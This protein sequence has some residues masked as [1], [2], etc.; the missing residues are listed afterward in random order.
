[1]QDPQ[2]VIVEATKG[3]VEELAKRNEVGLRRMYAILESD[4]YPKA[5]RRIRDIGA[6]NPDGARLIKCDLM[7]MFDDILA[8]DTDEVT[9]AEFLKE[10]N[11]AEHARIAKAPKAIRLQEDREAVDVINRDMCEIEKEDK[12]PVRIEMRGA[13][14]QRRN[15]HR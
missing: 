11:D 13:V 6:V 14:E 9:D 2:S 3:Y 8:P 10:L 4:W 1:M 7:A 12:P 5:K 15:G